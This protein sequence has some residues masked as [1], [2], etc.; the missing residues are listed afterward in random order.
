M[1]S[2]SADADMDTIHKSMDLED[3]EDE[4]MAGDTDTVTDTRE[5]M[6]AKD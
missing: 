4:D 2:R 6:P 1:V 3:M 5:N